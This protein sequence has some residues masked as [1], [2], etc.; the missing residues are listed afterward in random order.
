[1]SDPGTTYRTREEIQ[2]M[3]STRDPINGLKERIISSGLA[4][5]DFKSCFVDVVF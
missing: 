2:H 4:R 5:L 3:R 1:M